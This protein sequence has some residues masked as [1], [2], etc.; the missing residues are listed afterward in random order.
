MGGKRGVWG[1]EG[2][3][4]STQKGF[5]DCWI[6]QPSLARLGNVHLNP[7]ELGVG[8]HYPPPL[9]TPAHAAPPSR[10]PSCF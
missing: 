2:D 1:E 10:I 5:G 6:C 3:G 9:P 8:Y 7:R 4:K